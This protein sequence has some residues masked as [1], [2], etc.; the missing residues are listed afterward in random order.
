M[1]W[2][3]A[4]GEAIEIR[5]KNV[6][7]SAAAG[8]GKTAVL[9]ERIKQLILKDQVP[10][11]EM[12]V[13]TFS[14][15]A[16][17]EMRE[18]IIRAISA[19][20]DREGMTKKQ[21]LR[22]Q[23]S[24]VHKA[25]ISTFHAFSM[26]VIRRYF[27]LIDIEPNF[28]IC[29][30]AQ[31]SILQAN[32]M[33]QLFSD[34]FQSGEEEFL[35]F[36]NE[37]GK[38]KNENAVKGMVLN[39][40]TFIQSVPEPYVWLKEQIE[41]LNC[42]KEEFFKTSAFSEM[43]GDIERGL[44]LAVS[45]FTKVG[46]IL[47]DNGLSSLVP[48]S[49]EELELVERILL[50]F[51]TGD[52]EESLGLLSRIKYPQFRVSKEEKEVYEELKE[53]VSYV[54]EDGKAQIKRLVNQYGIRS[55]DDYIGEMNGTYRGAFYLGK[56]VEDFNQLY[57]EKKE[58]K[59]LIDFS[60]IEHY[61]LDILKD[62]RV[63]GEYGEKFQYIFVDEYQD[64]NIVQETLISRI[65]G[66]NNLFMVGDVKQSIYKFR[67]A[68]PE[69]FIEKYKAF[70]QDHTGYDQKID[71]NMN[72]RSKGKIIDS[73]NDIF[74]HIMQKES[75]GLDYDKGAALYQGVDYKGDLDY[76]V[77][78]HLVDDKVPEDQDLDEEIAE[79]K[80]AEVEA[81]AAA[82]ILKESVGKKIYD[83]KKQT[84]RTLE[85]KDM[86]ILLRGAR[87]VAD[88]YAEALLKE[89]I[90]SF[91]DT[92]DGY[93]D[94]VEIEVF[95]N[96][97][98]VMDNDKQDIPLLSVLR[99]PI[100][101]FT[102]SELIE[103]RLAERKTAYFQAFRTYLET[104]E[105]KDLK[106]K[107][108]DTLGKIEKWAKESTFMPFDDFLWR[109]IR[110]TGYYEYVGAIPGGQQRQAN[111]RALVDKAVQFQSTQNK[112]L[113]QF[114]KYIEAIK[115]EKVP[116][117]QVKLLGE[118][119]DVVRI[120]TIHKSKGLEFP[121]VLLG[122]LG[123]MFIKGSRNGVVSLHKDIGIGIPAI[124]GEHHSFKKSIMQMVVE[125]KKSREDL[126]EE[127]RILYVAFTRAMDKL[128]LLGTLPDVEKSMRTYA[129]QEHNLLN[130]NNYLDFIMPILKDTQVQL[131]HH[132]RRGISAIKTD[133]RQ[134]QHLLNGI[135][136][137]DQAE[138]PPEIMTEI[139]GRL[140]FVYPYEKALTL[141][142]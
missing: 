103:I 113:F 119:D 49:K 39:T 93:F 84:V 85:K 86:V 1:E 94:T 3:K 89:G 78:L 53:A 54:R 127:I 58:E 121:M 55:L 125:Q 15:A 73:V 120:M 56:L 83:G 110:E 142:S 112:G 67:L 68:E 19:E 97:L 10:L 69:I 64:S 99:S 47:E 38:T 57:R 82:S 109:I 135:L 31:K 24:K 52:F 139:K 46:E 8:S 27:Y 20:I 123:K 80:R 118:N 51:E 6:L 137:E 41:I 48:K 17:S 133:K 101:G 116:M 100:F 106:E 102:V 74:S 44:K 138:I 2:T 9:V 114:I 63:A 131:Y 16:A 35:W 43:K 42:S 104:G 115:K 28:K 81:F 140:E 95:M 50:S 117:G 129:L 23:L 91:L 75:S 141:K 76:P 36:L 66:L 32:A 60:D 33:E 134:R 5:G 62:D 18:K 90:P 34:R 4:Q 37:Y 70:Q 107:V 111:L 105:S 59:K 29:D 98:R 132:D 87:G 7:V 25:N 13:V 45:A 108:A 77:E 72:F 40:H 65:K 92:G 12:L 136:N 124:D 96:L 26:E 126:A 21:F 122:G 130:G 30:E 22:E 88:I 14:N 71:L 61:A 11:D 128:V 79:M